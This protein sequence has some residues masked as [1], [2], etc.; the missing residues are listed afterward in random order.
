MARGGPEVAVTAISRVH[1]YNGGGGAEGPEKPA[2]P[3]SCGHV[4]RATGAKSA[5]GLP[6]RRSWHRRDGDGFGSGDRGH[7]VLPRSSRSSLSLRTSASKRALASLSALLASVAARLSAS[8]R[9]AWC[10]SSVSRNSPAGDDQ[11]TNCV[12]PSES[13]YPM[14]I[15]STVAGPY[16]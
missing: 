1:G 12:Y 10:S 15:E 16:P 2:L 3:R 6:A 9:P 14:I 5:P 8:R 11:T 13:R 7:S 4:F